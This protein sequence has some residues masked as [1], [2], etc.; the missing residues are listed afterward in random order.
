[1]TTEKRMKSVVIEPWISKNEAVVITPP[2]IRY[3][4]VGATKPSVFL[5]GSIEMGVAED[6]QKKAIDALKKRTSVIYNPRRADWDASWEQSIDSPNFNAQVHWE[7]DMIEQA[8]AVLFHFDPATKSPITLMELGYVAS[9]KPTDVMVSCPAGFWRR[10][11][12][13]IMCERTGIAFFENL[14]DLLQAF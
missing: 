11:N 13:E 2:M 8:D 5:A 10:G 4:R 12:V 1:M 6:W 9:S 14:D 3:P 7:L